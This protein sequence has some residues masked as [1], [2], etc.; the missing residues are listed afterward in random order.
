MGP[1]CW[2]P[3]GLF[4]L[5]VEAQLNTLPI[6]VIWPNLCFGVLEFFILLIRISPIKGIKCKEKNIR[7]YL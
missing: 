6:L 1:V 2:A 4:D 3:I 5:F 7:I